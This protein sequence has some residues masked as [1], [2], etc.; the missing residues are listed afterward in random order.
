MTN[1]L[2][3]PQQPYQTH[4]DLDLGR[5][6]HVLPKLGQFFL[7][8]IHHKI[9]KTLQVAQFLSPGAENHSSTTDA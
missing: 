7:L 4:I 3:L 2:F 8:S 5:P 9:I 6:K 1:S